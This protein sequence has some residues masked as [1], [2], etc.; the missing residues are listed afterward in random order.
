MWQLPPWGLALIESE[1]D[2]KIMKGEGQ[3]NSYKPG[4]IAMTSVERHPNN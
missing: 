2:I 3:S 1:D 4:A